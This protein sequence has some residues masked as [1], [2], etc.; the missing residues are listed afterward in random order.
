MDAAV[1]HQPVPTPPLPPIRE[2][3]ALSDVGAIG[4]AVAVAGGAWWARPEPVFAVVVAVLVAAATR[5]PVLVC[6]AGFVVAGALGARAEAGI[7]PPEAGPFRGTVTLLDDPVEVPGG[8]RAEVRAG[9]RHLSMVVSGTGVGALD[10]RLA[11]DRLTVTGR[12]RPLGHATAYLHARHVAGRLDVHQVV[13]TSSGSLPWRMANTVHRAVDRSADFLP[14]D[15]RALY[16]G[17]LLGD[18]RGQPVVVAADMRASGLGHLLVVSGENVAFLLTLAG[19]LLRRIGLRVRWVA[20]IAL[21]SGFAVLT[22]FEPSVLRAV[23]MAA[24]GAVAMSRGRSVS[25]IRLLALSVAGL[26]LVDPFLV[27]QVGFGLSVSATAGICLLGPPLAGALPGPRS[28]AGAAATTIAAQI[29]VAPLAIAVFGGLPV[30]AVPANVL[31]APAAAAVLVWGLPAGLA[32]QFL[33]G[34]PAVLLQTPTRFLVAWIG[35]VARWSA[36]LPLGNLGAGELVALGVCVVAV[37]ACDRLGWRRASRATLALAVVALAV[38]AWRV[39]HPPVRQAVDG[40]TVWRSGA[41]LVVVAPGA[42]PDDLFDALH[43]LGVRRIDVL[44][45]PSG[46]PGPAT[47]IAELRQRWPIGRILAPPGNQIRDAVATRIGD[48]WRAGRLEITVG[49][50]A[51]HLEVSVSAAARQARR[52]RVPANRRELAPPLPCSVDSCPTTRRAVLSTG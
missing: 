18:A 6:A 13:H 37:V 48:R 24:L 34:A 2:R 29:G 27:H 42:R 21:V 26:V 32:A 39:A 12:V 45:A 31:A 19:P 7:H 25:T 38:P 11:G 36:A 50:E 4:L 14:A 8:V 51:P 46:G 28:L 49:R 41:T 3:R 1:A 33:G 10:A 52:A 5:R 30:A 43:R 22:R 35:G 16:R 23:A 20:V 9:H 15:Q 44:V 17:F 40:G 47:T